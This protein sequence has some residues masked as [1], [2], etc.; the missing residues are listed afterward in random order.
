MRCRRCG[1]ENPSS[2]R[3][4]GSCAAP[5]PKECPA[6]H[7]ENPTEFLFCGHCG[8]QLQAPYAGQLSAEGLE[9]PDAERRQLSVVFC[10]LAGSTALS[11]R[12]DPEDLRALIALYRSVC[13][14]VV[15]RWGGRIARYVGD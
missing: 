1:G 7:G 13:G 2:M 4:C 15:E 6:C 14:K 12:L 11:E 8:S 3:Y 10:D 5:L 9:K